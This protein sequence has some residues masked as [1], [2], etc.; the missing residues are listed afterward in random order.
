[1]AAMSALLTLVLGAGIGIGLLLLAA[2]VAGRRA[3]PDARLCGWVAQ[4]GRQPGHLVLRIGVPLA[5]A[6]AV[7]GVTGWPAASLLVAAGAWVAPRAF[8][9]RQRHQAELAKVEAI[10]AWAEML[11]DTMAAASGLEQGMVASAAVA[12]APIAPAVSRLAARLEHVRPDGALRA[13]ADDV[14]HPIAD[15]VVAGLIAA[16]DGRARELGPLLTQLAECARAEAQLRARIWAGRARTRT[17]VRVISGCVGLFALGLILLDRSYLAP[18][19]TP[20]G[21]VALLGIG[22]AFAGSVLAMERMSRIQL[23][24]RFVGRQAEVTL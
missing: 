19:G 9:G 21:Q 3:L 7:Y 6:I 1:V 17:S 14:D 5:V 2:G 10:A 24:D 22:G 4:G 8:G 23:P 11:R 13:F 15:F 12:P 20:A 18:Y 16:V